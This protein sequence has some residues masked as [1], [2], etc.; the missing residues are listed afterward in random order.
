MG[1]G[2]RPTRTFGGVLRRGLLVG[3]ERTAVVCGDVRL[4]HREL[5]DRTRRLGDAL[6]RRG[7]VPGDRVAVLAGNCHRYLELYLGLPAAGLVI[8]PINARHALPEIRYALQ[9]AGVRVLFADRQVEGIDDLDIRV[10]A[11]GDQ[12]EELLAGAEPVPWPDDRDE[13]DLAGIF[14]TGGTTGAPKGVMLT[15]GNLIAN[16]FA[17]MACWP[18]RRETRW[19]V[20][21]PFFHAA[22]TIGALATVW[23]G[24]NHVVLGPFD[25]GRFLDLVEREGITATLVVPAMMHALA[26]EQSREPRDVSSL[27]WLSHGSAP[28][29]TEL[30]RRTHD[31]FANADLMHIY[32]AT[33][34]SPIVTLMPGEQHLLDGP[35]ASS[36][37]Q[38]AVGVEVRTVDAM[39]GELCAPGEVG[40]VQV[41]GE[42]VTAGYWDKPAETEA[43]LLDGWYVSGDLGYQDE[44]GFLFLVD[45][46]KDMIVTGG[47]NVYSAEVEEALY[48]HP[49]V[50]E[51]A[52][53]AIPHERWGEAVHAVV[54]V[55]SGTTVSPEELTSHCSTL[56]AGYKVPKSVDIRVDPLPRTAVGKILKRD[57][58]EPY[59]EGRETHIA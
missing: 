56:I 17:F 12:Y 14:Y 3:G 40:E 10:I 8:V 49:A 19:L 32:G 44:E 11:M 36:C 41:R 25:A 57:L 13:D 30:L 21:A 23:A 27:R 54:T 24:G 6:A 37:G 7:L 28:A 5:A 33:E 29:A 58:R 45:R 51:A 55:A 20:V 2:G 1:R 18:F 53:I 35:R 16:A 52:V 26:A 59:W 22:G 38:A 46:S 15:H 47:E 9:D 39:T 31:A 42:N 48:R 4:T 34:T 50:A 43:A